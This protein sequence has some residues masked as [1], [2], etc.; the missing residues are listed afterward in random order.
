MSWFRKRRNT[1]LVCQRISIHFEC[2]WQTER[3][4]KEG[5]G[6]RNENQMKDKTTFLY[7]SFTLT[8]GIVCLF[9]LVSLL[10][11]PGSSC[12]SSSFIDHQK[13][14]N[15]NIVSD[16]F[17]HCVLRGKSVRLIPFSVWFNIKRWL[18]YRLW[19]RSRRE[20]FSL[21][22]VCLE[23]ERKDEVTRVIIQDVR[24]G[25]EGVLRLNCQQ[26]L[27]WFSVAFFPSHPLPLPLLMFSTERS[28]DTVS[29]SLPLFNFFSLSR[30]K[31][32][33]SASLHLYLI[34]SSLSCCFQSDWLSILLLFFV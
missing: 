26:L 34:S 12:L 29:L 7:H 24:E 4:W 17:P 27:I 15:S 8:A 9:K 2:N 5:R 1:W 6:I 23:K 31:H 21:L 18:S 28:F 14:L 19:E 20:Q 25:G 16:W 30:Q 10:S 13:E 33:R 3:V 32:K 11:P 22:L